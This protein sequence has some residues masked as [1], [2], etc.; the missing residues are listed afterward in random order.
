MT[1]KVLR[2]VTL[3]LYFICSYISFTGGLFGSTVS[4]AHFN[5]DEVF[6]EIFSALHWMALSLLKKREIKSEVI[7]F[8]KVKRIV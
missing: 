4:H 1:G 7:N 2:F 8:Y 5:M 3:K 6:I